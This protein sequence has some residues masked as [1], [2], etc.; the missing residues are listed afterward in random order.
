MLCGYCTNGMLKLFFRFVYEMLRLSGLFLLPGNSHYSTVVLTSTLHIQII[1]YYDAIIKESHFQ[2]RQTARVYATGQQL[3]K[4]IEQINP[5]CGA[6][7]GSFAGGV[8]YCRYYG[9]YAVISAEF[10]G[11]SSD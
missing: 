5:S 1:K 6:G 7:Q 3:I 11:R 4:R 9:Y 8:S 10:F 2:C